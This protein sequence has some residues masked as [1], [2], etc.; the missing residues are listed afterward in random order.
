MRIQHTCR[1]VA[2]TLVS[3]F[4]G[5]CRECVFAFV[6]LRTHMSACVIECVY[7]QVRMPLPRVHVS[8]SLSVSVSVSASVS[9]SVSLEV[10]VCE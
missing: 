4:S 10:S 2:A 3:S 7:M 9:A 8:L 5:G 1:P 6:C